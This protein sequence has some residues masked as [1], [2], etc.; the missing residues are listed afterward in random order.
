MHRALRHT[1]LAWILPQHNQPTLS[2]PR[3]HQLSYMLG[4]KHCRTDGSR[5][6]VFSVLWLCTRKHKILKQDSWFKNIT[7]LLPILRE[8]KSRGEGIAIP[9]SS[10][11]QSVTMSAPTQ[12]LHTMSF[13]F[14]SNVDVCTP[15][16]LTNNVISQPNKPINVQKGCMK[17]FYQE[18]LWY[19][20]H[21]ACK[22]EQLLFPTVSTSHSPFVSL[23]K[24]TFTFTRNEEPQ[25]S[26]FP[27]LN[28]YLQYHSLFTGQTK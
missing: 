7:N 20:C 1:S 5:R 17:G 2:A 22:W 4:T 21:H 18:W 15:L 9:P 27:K 26:H 24:L 28:H 3:P 6:R 8:K 19:S 13:S 14:F 10:S 25:V 12:A 11:F 16:C 23:P